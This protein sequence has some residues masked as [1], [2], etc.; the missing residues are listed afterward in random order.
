MSFF[1]A[2]CIDRKKTMKDMKCPEHPTNERMVVDGYTLDCCDSKHTTT[3]KEFAIKC[4]VDE[5]KNYTEYYNEEYKKTQNIL[6]LYN[7][8]DRKFKTSQNTVNK[9]TIR[10]NKL[11]EAIAKHN[12]LIL[13]RREIEQKRKY[14]PNNN[15]LFIQFFIHV[16]KALIIIYLHNFLLLEL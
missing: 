13:E 4:L 15:N 9:L 12:K 16:T 10:N 14:G 5:V 2:L 3:C 1:N 11:T 6:A 8:L 7:D